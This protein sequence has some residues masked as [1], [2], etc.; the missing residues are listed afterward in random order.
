MAFPSRPPF[1]LTENQLKQVHKM[2][3]KPNRPLPPGALLKLDHR[4][5][6][7]LALEVA[8]KL[9]GNDLHR[10]MVEG[11]LP[12][13]DNFDEAGYARFGMATKAGEL[14]LLG[15]VH[16]TALMPDTTGVEIRPQAPGDA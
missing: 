9:L 11:A 15:K 3:D 7:D 4:R 10:L 2:T 8:D 13:L 1:P 14:H 6:C 5:M 16:W 12:A